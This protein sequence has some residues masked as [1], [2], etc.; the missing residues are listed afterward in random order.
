[1]CIQRNKTLAHRNHSGGRRLPNF[2]PYFKKINHRP[3]RKTR[4]LL[5][6]VF[7]ALSRGLPRHAVAL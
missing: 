7:L 4:H 5:D 2:R 6:N 3:R 1:M